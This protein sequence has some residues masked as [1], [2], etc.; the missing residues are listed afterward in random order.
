MIL[1]FFIRYGNMLQKADFDILSEFSFKSE[2]KKYL[3]REIL[4]VFLKNQI[5]KLELYANID[6]MPSDKIDSTTVTLWQFSH[7]LRQSDLYQKAL[8]ATESIKM[9]FNLPFINH[10]DRINYLSEIL[11]DGLCDMYHKLLSKKEADNF[12]NKMSASETIEDKLL[13]RFLYIKK[14]VS[15]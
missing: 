9:I 7:N 2:E 1:G 12:L 3:Q 13:E 10:N 5:K 4:N 6:N 8:N 15:D 11:N 14:T